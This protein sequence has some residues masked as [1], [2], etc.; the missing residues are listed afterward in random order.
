MYNVCRLT[1]LRTL[2]TAFHEV[3]TVPPDA[4]GLKIV[5]LSTEDKEVSFIFHRKMN[6]LMYCI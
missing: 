4:T 1:R 2:Q 6:N 3:E 5:T